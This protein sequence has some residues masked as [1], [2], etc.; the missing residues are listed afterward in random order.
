MRVL[1]LVL[2]ISAC[3]SD[4]SDSSNK[5]EQKIKWT[6]EQFEK[7]R[8]DC[9]SI[10]PETI[11]EDSLFAVCSCIVKGFAV[12]YTYEDYSVNIVDLVEKEKP[13]MD[14]CK[15]DYGEKL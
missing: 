7:E 6:I 11:T 9:T 15:E 2:L 3:G 13:M 14:K 5:S 10:E 1:A 4:D 12:K 8:S